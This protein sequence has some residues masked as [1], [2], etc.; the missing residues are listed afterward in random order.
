MDL[1]EG[2]ADTGEA[3]IVTETLAKTL[4]ETL[5]TEIRGVDAVGF[6]LIE[7][8]AR[9]DFELAVR[10]IAEA[11]EEAL[12]EAE[13]E[14]EATLEEAW[15]EDEA[16]TDEVAAFEEDLADNKDAL[17]DALEDACFAD[18]EAALTDTLGMLTEAEWKGSRLGGG[19]SH[20]P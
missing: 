20:G 17:E 2:L 14:E 10:D 9:K 7:D 1:E 16:W 5:A 8:A 19:R 11:D 4:A 18:N 15:A 12:A 13:V 6:R 3:L